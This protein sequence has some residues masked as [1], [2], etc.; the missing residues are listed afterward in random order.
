MD[1]YKCVK[2]LIVPERIGYED[3][4]TGNDFVVEVG[5]VWWREGESS[6][7][8]Q[9][10]GRWLDIGENTISEHFDQKVAQRKDD[11]NE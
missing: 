4:A 8:T 11:N 7:L 1:K 3:E 2:R 9:E 5:E 6:M 10:C